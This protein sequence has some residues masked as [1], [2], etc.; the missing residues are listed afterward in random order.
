M[1]INKYKLN[2]LLLTIV[3]CLGFLAK[4]N[5]QITLIPDSG[6]EQALIDLGIDSDGM[7]NGQ[8]LT[9][10]I[11]GVIILDVNYSNIQ[12]LTGIEDFAALEILDVSGN[13]LI[14][15]NVSSN[16]ELKEL[17]NSYLYRNILRANRDYTY[18]PDI[19]GN[20]LITALDTDNPKIGADYAQV[21]F[22]LE[23]NKLSKGQTVHVYGNFNNYAVDNTTKLTYF[24]DESTYEGKLLLKQGFYSYKYV[25]KNKDGSIDENAISGNFWQTENNY[26]VLVYYRDLGARYDRIIGYGEGNSVDITN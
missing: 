25:I 4:I 2:V 6:F 17:Y 21:H 19:N 18:N 10:D 12:D 11:E 23:L 26:K 15:L 1:E 24:D 13:E 8:V 3:T 20:F 7:I 5:A 9:M 16:I 14:A 22:T